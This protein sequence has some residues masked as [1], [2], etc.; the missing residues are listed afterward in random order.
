MSTQTTGQI[1]ERL[2]RQHLRSQGYQILATNWR[3]AE[4]ELDIVAR[5][6]ET[7]VFV[8]VRARRAP[9]TE[10]ALV[11]IDPRKQEQLAK[12]AYL[13]LDAHD[14]DSAAWRIDVIAVAIPRAGA[15][16]VEQVV[17]ALDW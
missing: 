2:A 15:A 16:I 9:T 13:Y 8:E 4:G 6:A 11:S 17:N 1:G 7:I 12:L 10:S 5:Q 3:C 14:L